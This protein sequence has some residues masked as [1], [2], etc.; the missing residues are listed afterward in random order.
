MANRTLYDHRGSVLK[1]LI[2]DDH[3][4]DGVMHVRTAQDLEPVLNLV[5]KMADMNRVVGHRK[6]KQMVPVA[7][8]PLVIYEKAM[9]E[10]WSEDPAA[11][12]RWLNDPANRPFRITE[13]RV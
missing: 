11:W 1:E 8:I 12:K 9:R 13:G 10:G 2:T 5:K 6:S 3:D 7:E 4:A